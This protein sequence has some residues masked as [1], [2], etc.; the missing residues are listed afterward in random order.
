MEKSLTYLLDNPNDIKH[1]TS[2]KT[3]YETFK[4]NEIFILKNFGNKAKGFFIEE[5]AYI[6]FEK[7]PEVLFI[8]KK[9]EYN[10]E[11]FEFKE[12]DIEIT[13]KSNRK[14]DGYISLFKSDLANYKIGIPILLFLYILI[15]CSSNEMTAL[16]NLNDTIINIVSIFIGTLFVFATL[17]YEK[18]EISQAIKNGKAQDM[19]FTDK[20]IFV[21]SMLSLICVIISN[22]IIQYVATTEFIIN[23][24]QYIKDNAYFLY[25]I[26]KYGSVYILTG[27]SVTL[28]YI[29]FKSIIDYYL[30]KIKSQ[31]INTQIK[32]MKDSIINKKSRKINP[33]INFY[34]FKHPPIK[35]TPSQNPFL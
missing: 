15:F 24:K 4:D 18:E 7:K 12:L 17:F 13:G 22:G 30:N 10:R 21:L 31:A 8:L 23:F 2:V 11:D 3:D 6:I 33:T 28:N 25:W 35:L 20:Y 16:E 27:I 32:N 14:S 19:F 1:I 34:D 26:I 29:C 9:K 5:S